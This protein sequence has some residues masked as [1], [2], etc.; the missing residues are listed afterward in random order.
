MLGKV[1]IDWLIESLKSNK[2][3]LKIVCVGGQTINNAAVYENYTIFED[4]GL[5]YSID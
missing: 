3:S 4:S 5:T 2:A 1:Q